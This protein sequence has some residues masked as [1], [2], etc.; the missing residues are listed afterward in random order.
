VARVRAS[1]AALDTGDGD[2][3]LT[4]LA[5]DAIVDDRTEPAPVAGKRNIASWAKRR[6]VAF[7]GVTSDVTTAFGVGDFVLLESVLRGTFKGPWGRLAAP[8]RP[9]EIHRA[10]IAQVTNGKLVR[11][12]AYWNFKE[13]AQAVGQWPPTAPR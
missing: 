9:F 2:A 5:E 12:S 10:A 11:V 6:A 7:T 8:N 13:L 4:S 3:F 1:L